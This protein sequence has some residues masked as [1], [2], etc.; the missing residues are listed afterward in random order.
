MCTHKTVLGWIACLLMVAVGAAAPVSTAYADGADPGPYG[1]GRQIVTITRPANET[2]TAQLYYPATSTGDGAP[3]D[4]NG[5]PYPA[6]TFAHGFTVHPDRYRSTMEHLASHGYLVVAPESYTSFWFPSHQG[7]AN[8]LRYSLDYMEARNV[9]PGSWLFEQVDTA[10][11]GMTGHS[12]GGG[13]S[14]LATAADPRVRALATLA[15][16]ETNPSAI[17][18]MSNIDVPVRLL[19]GDQDGIVNWQTNSQAMYDAGGPPRQLPLI[20]GGWH[21]GFLDSNIL[22]CDSG[23]LPRAKQLEISRRE[24]VTFFDLYLKPDVDPWREVWGPEQADDPRTSLQSDP[25]IGLS[26]DSQAGQGTPG[27]VVSYNVTLTN[28]D[29]RPTSYAMLA[30]DDAWPPAPP[31]WPVTLVPAQTPI[32]NPGESTEVVVEVQLPDTPGPEETILVSAR[33]NLDGGTRQCATVTSEVVA[34]T[35]HVGNIRMK[36]QEGDGGR[37]RVLGLVP[38]EDEGNAPVAGATVSAEWTLPTGQSVVRSAVTLASGMARF[39]IGSRQEGL[40]TLTV[41]LVE[42]A[43]FVYD[44]DQNL[45][46]SE[47]LIVP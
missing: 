16:A 37:Y 36:Y 47:Q 42:A 19:T 34:S 28:L 27:S 30:E 29:T 3:Y 38:V 15:A 11:V 43:G 4:S 14:I 35:M 9:D 1:A 2:F 24:L 45:E 22:F 12:M 10:H 41:M 23:P 8:D 5:A 44:P 18:Q 39:Q 6:V 32:L 33:S 26:P 7:F 13:S 40:Y 17:D 20:L 31:P 46:T 25:G 21:C